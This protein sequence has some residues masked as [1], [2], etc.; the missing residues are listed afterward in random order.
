M[1]KSPKI[2][3]STV[4][5]IN[6]SSSHHNL[7][8]TLVGLSLQNRVSEDQADPESILS[9]VVN[10]NHDRNVNDNLPI[11]NQA[12]L[13]L[14]QQSLHTPLSLTMDVLK[15]N[16]SKN[17]TPS[18]PNPSPTTSP[19]RICLDNL[20]S[21]IQIVLYLNQ[22]KKTQLQVIQPIDLVSPQTSKHYELTKRQDKL[23]ND[24]FV[25]E[26]NAHSPLSKTAKSIP[27]LP[28]IPNESCKQPE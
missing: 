11:E 20:D 2:L 22:A 4:Q 1:T 23:A 8:P 24:L 19:S 18:S 13:N 5:V 3:P 9:S 21:G 27:Y 7:L 6:N 16:S 10:S 17:E 12:N 28:S 26:K 25:T 15:I 14:L